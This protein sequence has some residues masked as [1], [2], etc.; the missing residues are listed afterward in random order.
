M[1]SAATPFLSMPVLNCLDP[2]DL[3]RELPIGSRMRLLVV[4]WTVPVMRNSLPD[5]EG[6]TPA[7]GIEGRYANY[8]S[9]GHNAFE[10]LIDFGQMFP[11][12]REVHTWIITSPPYAKELL[13]VLSQSIER[14]EKQFGEIDQSE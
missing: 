14:Y 10:F 9:V 6:L 2:L 5:P 3:V 13:R 11:G 8:F 4:S 1:D 7:E 12:R